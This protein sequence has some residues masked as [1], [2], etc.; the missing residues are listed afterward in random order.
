MGNMN[1]RKAA[2]IGLLFLLM[3]R[4]LKKGISME[5]NVRIYIKL[6]AVIL[7][8]ILFIWL[9]YTDER[10]LQLEQPEGELIRASDM[11]ILLDEL[12]EGAAGQIDAAALR[13]IY[14]KSEEEPE[15]YVRYDTYIEILDCIFGAAEQSY[16]REK[17]TYKNKY[18]G[19]FLLLKEDWYGCFDRLLSFYGLTD[20]IAKKEVEILGGSG[21]F[22]GEKVQ[23]GSLLGIDGTV[24]LCASGDFM[25]LKYTTVEAYTRENR[26]L[27]LVEILPDESSLENVWIMEDDGS[28]IQFFY[29]GYELLGDYKREG[30]SFESLREQ[31][32]TIAFREETIFD[33]EIKGER[34]SGKLL[35]IS[36]QQIEI[37]GY[38]SLELQEKNAGYKLYEDLRKAD[39]SELAI[40]YDFAD[41]VLEDGKV[42]AFL[43]TR[44]EKMETIRV[45]VKNNNFGSLYHD[46]ITLS[47]ESPMTIYY[48]DYENRKEER[49][50][51]GREI[52]I[53]AGDEYLKGNR[54]EIVPDINTGKIRVSSLNRSQGVPAYRGHME[55]LETKEGLVLINEVLL[56]EYLYSVVPSEMPASYPIEALKAQAVCARTYGYRYLKQPGYGELGA[57][58][59]DSVGYQVYNNIAENVNSTKAVKETTGMLLLY[60][61]EPVSTY[62][63]STSC[64]Y[65]AD[66]GVWNEE[67]KEQYPYLSAV[68]IASAEEEAYETQELSVE[69]N[70]RA[71]ITQ[72][73]EN[74]Y[75]KEEPWFRWSYQ[76]EKLDIK[77]LY[78]RLKERYEA[79]PGK[80]LTLAEKGGDVE[81]PELFEAR[82][83]KEFK[84]VYDIR[85][86]SRKEG[87]VMDELLI[88]TDKGTYKVISEYNIRYVLNQGGEVIRQDGSSYE[89]NVLLPSAYLIID[90]VKSDKN[91]I[92][93]N[94]SGGGY[95]HGVGMSQ[96][97]ARAMGLEN[98]DCESI[99]S[100]YFRDCQL[101]QVY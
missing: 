73:D 39:W 51:A 90:T 17:I 65:G 97:G 37:E 15:E 7:L 2:R 28:T 16:E 53:E 99:L 22:A 60:E 68:H 77:M 35:S 10:V 19:E 3:K 6:A 94:I 54:V 4:G 89:S 95:G 29:E 44:K 91:V 63:Y 8:T 98:E 46:K 33:I 14:R 85:S 82:E 100:F 21:I 20:V 80:V 55:I 38:G 81:N 78:Q 24:Y 42:C 9:I 11:W 71:Y 96:N 23:E 1:R 49:V 61:E 66:A 84:K 92:G 52:T 50:E 31:V 88:E 72:I 76:V 30:E 43:I 70:F 47:G 57:H 12:A 32:G 62:Y 25:N 13:E 58:V 48:G 79:A 34:I 101:A 40:G 59:D 5:E 75:E 45:A 26:L 64:G 41:F 56:E 83:P 36:E 93:Y 86:L 87:G 67:Q 18:R 74:A 27:T 69:E